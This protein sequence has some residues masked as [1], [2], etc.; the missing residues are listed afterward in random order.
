MIPLSLY[1]VCESESFFICKDFY[2]HKF[3]PTKN[4]DF[5]N[6]KCLFSSGGVCHF[7]HTK[8]SSKEDR[9]HHEYKTMHTKKK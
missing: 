5:K 2:S 9:Q 7:A 4:E 8:F 1:V 3:L 6:E